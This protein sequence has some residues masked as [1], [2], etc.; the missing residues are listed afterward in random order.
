MKNEPRSL[1]LID[2]LDP[3]NVLGN[4][5]RVSK[6][7]ASVLPPGRSQTS[8]HQLKRLDAQGWQI[9]VVAPLCRGQSV[10]EERVRRLGFPVA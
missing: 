1:E 4:P 2:N 9:L 7:A 3:N 10:A 8:G 5:R 6:G